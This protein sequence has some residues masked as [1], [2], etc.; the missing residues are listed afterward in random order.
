HH[1]YEGLDWLAAVLDEAPR[2]GL[3]IVTVDD[4]VRD[5]PVVA[6]PQEP[7]PTSWGTPRTLWTW[8]GPQVAD[9]AFAARDAELRTVA[10]GVARGGGGADER[11]VRELLALQ[12]SDWAFLATR[13]ISGSYPR[14]RAAGHLAALDAALAAPGTWDPALRA[15]APYA[16]SGMLLVP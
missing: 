16:D 11:A 1:W 3:E 14:E 12:S 2:A 8:S 5:E 10:A 13:D 6:A 4:A 15:L 9:L 7:P